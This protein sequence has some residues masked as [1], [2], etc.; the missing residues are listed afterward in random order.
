MSVNGRRIRPGLNADQLEVRA[1]GKTHK[2]HLGRVVGVRTAILGGQ[3][4]G[5]GQ[6]LAHGV[7]MRAGYGNVVDSQIE[8]SELKSN[9]PAYR[10]ARR[11]FR[12]PCPP[13]IR[14]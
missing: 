7:E 13:E 8:S 1:V 5:R 9:R 11:A 10:E 12:E 2:R 4:R 6:G 3:I 14:A